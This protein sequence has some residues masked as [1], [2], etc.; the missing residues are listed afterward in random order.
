MEARR[1]HTNR[2]TAAVAVATKINIRK[3]HT[4]VKRFIME[5]K[6]MVL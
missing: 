4:K 3:F 1:I 6:L 2:K 5:I